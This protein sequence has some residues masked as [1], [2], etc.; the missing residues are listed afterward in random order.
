[1]ISLK[2]STKAIGIM[3]N[4]NINFT[5][6]TP[7]KKRRENIA[8]LILQGQYYPDTKTRQKQFKKREGKE[9]YRLISLM[10]LDTKKRSTVLTS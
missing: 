9:N 6:S 3:N 8:K 1:M 4:N 10:K 5:Q 2:N 7:E